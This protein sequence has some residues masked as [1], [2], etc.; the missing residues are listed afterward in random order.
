MIDD[1]DRKYLQRCVDLASEALD[2]GNEPFGSVLVSSEGEVLFEDYN[3]IGGGDHTQHPEFAIARWAANNMDVQDRA[4]ATVYTSGEHCPMCAAAIGFAR[5]GRLYF[6]ADDPKSGGVRHGPRIYSH[7]QA[8]H[9]P[10][11][12]EGIGA[13]ESAALLR[14]F[15]AA[16]RGS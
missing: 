13:A 12:Y 16:R 2:R 8:H 14:D 10:E 5:I 1:T 15:F 9:G 3:R 4:K 7:P 6:G 11:V